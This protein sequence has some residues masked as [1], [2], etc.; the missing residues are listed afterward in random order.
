MLSFEAFLAD[1]RR[2]LAKIAT[3]HGIDPGDVPGIAFIA[4]HEASASYNPG[5]GAAFTTW[6]VRRFETLCL[7]ERSQGLYGLALDDE[8]A[9]VPEAALARLSVS[10]DQA[11]FNVLEPEPEPLVPK[12]YFGLQGKIID[13]AL[14]GCDTAQIAVRAGVT[15]RR[16]NQLIAEMTQKRSSATQTDLFDLEQELAA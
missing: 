2:R 15:P 10:D 7:R 1:Y 12:S 3:I 8:L 13:A 16:V 4:W 9:T 6:A 14:D 11:I 5:S